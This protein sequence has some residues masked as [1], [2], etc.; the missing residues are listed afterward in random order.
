MSRQSKVPAVTVSALYIS[1]IIIYLWFGGMKFTAYEAN[2]IQGLVSN[3]PIVAWLYDFLTVQQVAYLIGSAEIGIAILLSCRF[4]KANL[5]MLGAL[6]STATFTLTA[7]FLFT[8]PGIV[9]PELG[10]P[11]ITVMPGQFLLKDIVLLTL[12]AFLVIES[13]SANRKFV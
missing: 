2:A 12:S 7:S 9:E 11:A 6:A 1:L 4:F 13:A 10:F 8:T 5:A 3:S